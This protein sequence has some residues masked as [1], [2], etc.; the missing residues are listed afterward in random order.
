MQREDCLR[1]LRVFLRELVKMLR[2]DINLMIFSKALMS[3][4]DELQPQIIGF[5]FKDRVFNS[6]VDL[7]CLSMFLSVSS[8]IR[9]AN[10]LM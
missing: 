8:Q 6:M 10:F 4:W 9:E 5:E 2:Y 3:I 7:I 1:T